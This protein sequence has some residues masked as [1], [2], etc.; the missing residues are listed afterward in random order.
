M[1]IAEKLYLKQ[2]DILHELAIKYELDW[3][4]RRFFFAEYWKKI[5]SLEALSLE[6]MSAEGLYQLLKE[7]GI[8]VAW[9]AEVEEDEYNKEI[10]RLMMPSEY[11]GMVSR[12]RGRYVQEHREVL[13]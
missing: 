13:K 10:E 4:L 2:P 12:K 7:Y 11:S 6:A 5:L 1:T 9:A 8:N 3:I